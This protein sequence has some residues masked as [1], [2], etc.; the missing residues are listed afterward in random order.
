MVLYMKDLKLLDFPEMDINQERLK[1]ILASIESPEDEYNTLD[2][3]LCE[4]MNF[5]SELEG[6]EVV[7]MCHDIQKL[8]GALEAFYDVL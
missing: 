1:S 8:R 7:M 3:I 5:L 2:A 6:D 4:I